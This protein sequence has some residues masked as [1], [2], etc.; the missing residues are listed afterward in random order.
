MGKT[1]TKRR[2][3]TITTKERDKGRYTSADKKREEELARRE[4]E[5]RAARELRDQLGSTLLEAVPEEEFVGLAQELNIGNIAPS[6]VLTERDVAG[7]DGYGDL[8]DEKDL[9]MHPIE[10]DPKAESKDWKSQEVRGSLCILSTIAQLYAHTVE[11][12]PIIFFDDAV[13]QS[14]DPIDPRQMPHARI[15]GTR[16]NVKAQRLW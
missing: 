3:R 2:K 14:G 15:R 16:F 9:E 5:R 6:S 11:G 1:V 13:E 8:I 10:L 7:V 4:E 12:E